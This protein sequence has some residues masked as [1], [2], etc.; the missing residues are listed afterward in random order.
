MRDLEGKHVERVQMVGVFAGIIQEAVRSMGWSLTK[1]QN[2]RLKVSV[3]IHTLSKNG[4]Q[5]FIATLV[6][7]SF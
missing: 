7:L 5:K 6:G 4:L 3:K 2:Q 1:D